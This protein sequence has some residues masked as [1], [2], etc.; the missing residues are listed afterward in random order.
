MISF[1]NDY[2]I[3][4]TADSDLRLLHDTATTADKTLFFAGNSFLGANTYI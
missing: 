4:Y 1:F 3:P 2:F